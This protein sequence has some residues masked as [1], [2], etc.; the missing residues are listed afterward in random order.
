MV[1]FLESALWGEKRK[2]GMKAQ[3]FWGIQYYIICKNSLTDSAGGE[4]ARRSM[5][6]PFPPPL[7]S[8]SGRWGKRYET[9]EDNGEQT[10]E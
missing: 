5:V 1:Y 6:E 3:T 7:Q 8:S 10:N 2:I 9:E 4:E